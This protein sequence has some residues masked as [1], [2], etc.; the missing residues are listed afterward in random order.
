MT[1][2][3]LHE[4]IESIL[5]NKKQ[6]ELLRQASERIREDNGLTRVAHEVAKFLSIDAEK[7]E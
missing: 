1:A 3:Q 4:S 6:L 2:E 5:S 7:K